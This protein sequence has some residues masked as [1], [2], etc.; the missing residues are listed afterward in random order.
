MGQDEAGQHEKE[1]NA[2]TEWDLDRLQPAP[3][4]V[5]LGVKENYRE[6]GKEAK[7][8]EWLQVLD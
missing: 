6:R 8:S 1:G 5:E 4:G 3:F 7:A 2:L